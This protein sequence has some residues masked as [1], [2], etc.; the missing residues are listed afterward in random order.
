MN[1][2]RFFMENLVYTKD[3]DVYLILKWLITVH[4]LLKRLDNPYV[5]EVICQNICNLQEIP[6]EEKY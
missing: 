1:S 4:K 2:C 5:I 6:F 3:K